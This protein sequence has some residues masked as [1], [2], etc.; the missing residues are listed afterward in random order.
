MKY[1]YGLAARRSAFPLLGED[2]GDLEAPA[3]D[4]LR[5]DLVVVD[6]VLCLL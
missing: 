1:N 3:L 6:L 2:D 4:L 5:D